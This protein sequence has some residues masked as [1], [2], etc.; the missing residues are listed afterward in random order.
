M[1]GISGVEKKDSLEREFIG[2]HFVPDRHEE[3][4]WLTSTP[5]RIINLDRTR[6][7]NIFSRPML[8]AI[9]ERAVETG[10]DAA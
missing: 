3:M 7:Q 2:Q 6:D 8:S 1:S 4:E 9:Y 5:I 10:M